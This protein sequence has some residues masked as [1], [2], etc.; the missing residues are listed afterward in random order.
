MMFPADQHTTAS[1]AEARPRLAWSRTGPVMAA[2]Y[3]PG[4][5]PRPTMVSRPMRRRPTL[6]SVAQNVIAQRRVS[7][8]KM[9]LIGAVLAL[10]VV[11]A[12]C[13]DSDKERVNA[14]WPDK[15]TFG[16]VPSAEQEKLQDNVDPIMEVLEDALG[17]EVEGVVTTDYPG[18]V[19]AM[20][21]GQADLGAF[22]PFG[23][24]LAQQQF[25]NMKVLIQAIRYGAAT[26]HGQWMTND[27][28]ICD[29]PPQSGT[30]LEN[31]DDG[32][33][34][35]GALDAVALQVGVYFG[36]SGKALGETV[37]AGAVSPGMSCTADL[38]K[39]VGK[40]VAF[41]SESSTSG[42]IYPAL[43]LIRAGIDP[44]TDIVPIFSGSHDASVA[45]VYN[46]D[47]DIG[48]SYD[49][50]RRSMRKTNPDVGDKV[51]V[52]NITGEI[53]NDVVAA[54][55]LLPD[56]LQNAVYNAISAY[57]MTDE[58]EA[59]FD[60]MYGWTDIRRAVESDFDIVREAAAILGITEP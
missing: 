57:L 35:V 54:S 24:V 25:G 21:T 12:A 17:I 7:V 6:A 33:T 43:Q 36:D 45:A 10:S 60:E 4:Q 30:A 18:L 59:A 52:F 1:A 16:F 23:Y 19:T 5:P 22:G 40:R 13:S 3:G 48:I 41:T 37:D 2:P 50:A 32:I 38:S 29:S 44:E 26:Y 11:A 28:S 14:S 46:G 42:Y 58:G 20:G 51:I 31:G 9:R 55:S 27:P 56:S 39:V 53:P 47:A 8:R 34:Q 15:I 49:D